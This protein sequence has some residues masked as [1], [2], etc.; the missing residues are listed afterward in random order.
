MTARFRA[1]NISFEGLLEA[2]PD[3]MVVVDEDGRVLLVNAQTERMFGYTRSELVGRPIEDLVP[4]RYRGGHLQ[5]RRRFF[6]TPSVR[7]MGAGLELNGRR[8][9]GTEFPVEISLSPMETDRGM[10]AIAAI[11]DISER[12]D[13]EARFRG[14]LESAPD[15]IVIV[16]SGGRIVLV[17]AQAERLF[18]YNRTE[19]IHQPI[20]TLVPDSSRGKHVGQRDSYIKAPAVRPMGAGLPLHGQ[21]KDGSQFPVEISLSPIETKEGTLVASAIRDIRTARRPR[22]GSGGCSSPPRTRS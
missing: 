5:H 8:R 10:V 20:E 3:A 19:L 17:N 9:D 2:A 15:A 6:E 22:R 7:P 14:L 11:R 13:A 12:K 21:R 18:G 16:D 1:P 4:E